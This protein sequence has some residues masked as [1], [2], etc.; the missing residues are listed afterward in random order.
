MHRRRRTRPP[1]GRPARAGWAIGGPARRHPQGPGR[2]RA[3]RSD[4][5][6]EG[7]LWGHTLRSP[8]PSARIRAIDIGPAL[9]HRRGA[10]RAHRR[11]RARLAHLRPGAPRPTGAR[12]RRRALRGRAGGGRGRRP[13]RDRPAGVRGHRGRLRDLLAPVADPGGAPTRPAIHP[14][15][16]VFR[17]LVIRHGDLDASAGPVVVEGT[18]DVGHAGPG[19]HGHRG[20]PGHPRRRRRGRPVR[21]APRAAQRPRPGVAECLGLPPDKVRLPSAG[22]AAPSAPARTSACRST[23]C[24][25]ALHT[26]RPVK[27]VYYREE[28]FF[29]HV[30]RHPARI[31]YAP[32]RRSPTARWSAS[33][34]A[35]CSTAAPTASTTQRW[36]PTPLLRGRA[37]PGAQRRRRGLGGAHQQ[38]AVRRHARLR[39]GA[40]LLRATRPR[41]TGWPPPCGI[42]PV[43]LR[44]RNALAPG[45]RAAH[46]PGHRPAPLPVAEVIR[47]LRRRSRSRARAADDALALPGRQPAAPPTAADVRRGVGFA[48]GFKNLMFAEGY[49]TAPT[50]RVPPGRRRSSPSPAPAPRSA[51]ASSPSPSRSPA[52]CSASTRWSLAPADT[53]IGSAGST[54]ASRQ[55]WMSG[56]AVTGRGR[57]RAPPPAR[58]RGHGHGVAAGRGARRW[59]TAG[60]DRPDGAGRPLGGRGQRRRSCSR[61]PSSTTTRLTIPL[62]DDGQGDAHLSFAFAAHRAV[63]D[64][65]PELGPG[66]GRRTWPPPRTWAGSSTRCRLLGQLEGG[67]AQGVGL[68]VMEEIVV[69]DGRDAQPV[70]H[71]LPHPDRARPAR[72]CGWRR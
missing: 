47:D 26:G 34:P 37:L 45:R 57:G 66:P 49:E 36:S 65:D 1:A 71:R 29:G 33:R 9:A 68:A 24:L 43:E 20:R 25:L 27:M 16:N 2:V 17:D 64:V 31:W 39:R 23:L 41:W 10:R 28:S 35:S 59:S 46:R 4:L 32:H 56:G 3:S 12:P 19:L 62:D 54:S 52:R 22:W 8:H 61:R 30:H 38:P 58:A 60:C 6:A 53:S 48:V 51:R 69:D 67:I 50:A 55:T 5:W 42:D 44:L 13:P 18:Y 70:V 14:D 40:D 72:R 63:V 15:G 21:V 7:M 11:R